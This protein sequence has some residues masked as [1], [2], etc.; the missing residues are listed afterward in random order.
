VS[1]VLSAVALPACSGSASSVL[2]P[3]GPNAQTIDRLWWLML[4]ISAVVFA[5]VVSM[6]AVAIARRRRPPGDLRAT[7]RWGPPFIAIAGVVVPALVLGGTAAISLVDY[8]RATKDD[9]V[10]TVRVVGHMWWWEARYPNGAV[11]A[12]EIH[13]PVGER[14]R[15]ELSTADVIHSF[16]VPELAQKMDMVPGLHNV[17][18]LQADRAGVYRGQ[19]AE[20]CGLQHAHMAFVVV[21]EPMASFEAWVET[22][23]G[24]AESPSSSSARRGQDV[25]LSSTCF[26][27]H[28]I[29]G[30]PA[31]ASIGPDLTHLASR[32]AIAAEVLDNTR[33]NLER[34]I[35]APQQIK[36]GAVMPPTRLPADRL[37]DLVDYL[38]TL[39]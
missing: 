1:L 24:P 36:P 25:F 26:G 17:L 3:S 11:T 39:G 12:N 15:F 18:T 6:T 8:V 19:C 4:W 5:V 9:G 7:P 30:S 23:A 20:Y 32:D 16:W 35:T 31:D 33:A 28:T 14:V 38:E 13:I 2:R 29:R 37:R 22:M 10:L 27:C 21:A 34:W